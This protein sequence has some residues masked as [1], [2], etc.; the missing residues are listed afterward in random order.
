MTRRDVLIVAAVATLDAALAW[1]GWRSTMILTD[2][3]PYLDGARNLLEGGGSP[4]AGNL[5]SL[6]SQQGPSGRP[7]TA[8]RVLMLGVFVPWVALVL[9]AE[10]ERAD[11][12]IWIWSLLGQQGIANDS[13]CPEGVEPRDDWR[14]VQTAPDPQDWSGLVALDGTFTAGFEPR[15]RFGPYVVYRR[16]ALP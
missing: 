8:A 11:R 6:G 1:Q 3:L 9:F 12:W 15:A 16:A 14:I 13:R 5:S 4:K 7:V 2:S 10:P